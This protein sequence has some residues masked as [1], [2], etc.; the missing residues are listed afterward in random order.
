MTSMGEQEDT[1]NPLEPTARP[2]SQDAD[3]STKHTSSHKPSLPSTASM[4]TVRLSDPPCQSQSNSSTPR[5][6]ISESVRKSLRFSTHSLTIDQHDL[7]S[8]EGV[9]VDDTAAEE[10]EDDDVEGDGRP[11]SALQGARLRSSSLDNTPNRLSSPSDASSQRSRSNSSGTLSSNESA[12]VDWDELD[13]SEEQAPRDEGSDE[14]GCY[15][16]HISKG[17]D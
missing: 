7:H 11:L 15:Q 5:N 9:L 16:F 1:N 6:S 12:Q 2:P 4:V 8:T 13:K 17:S 10:E 3:V 14:V